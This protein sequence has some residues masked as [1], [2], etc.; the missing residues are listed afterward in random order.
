[1]YEALQIVRENYS[2]FNVHDGAEHFFC[3]HCETWKP[4]T[5]NRGYAEKQAV[6]EAGL[7]HRI[8]FQCIGKF[9]ASAYLAH[10][11]TVR[12]TKKPDR[13]PADPNPLRLRIEEPI[14]PAE[15]LEMEMEIEA[16]LIYLEDEDD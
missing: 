3:N 2:A 9:E 15:L 7:H 1:M 12:W 8:C 14:Q 13:F 10:T 4:V 11:K 5:E 6:N 16:L